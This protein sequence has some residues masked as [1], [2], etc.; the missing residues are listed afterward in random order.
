MGTT[1]T[2]LERPITASAFPH[3]DS[4]SHHNRVRILPANDIIKAYERF[5]HTFAQVCFYLLA[6]SGIDGIEA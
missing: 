2:E 3:K 5:G 1:P 6:E 4:L